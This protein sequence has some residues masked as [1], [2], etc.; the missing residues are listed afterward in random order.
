MANFDFE[1]RWATMLEDNGFDILCDA[2]TTTQQRLSDTAFK[3]SFMPLFMFAYQQSEAHFRVREP[4]RGAQ[5]SYVEES[6]AS[7]VTGFVHNQ[8]RL[9]TFLQ[10]FFSRKAALG[11][12]GFGAFG[13]LLVKH[14][15]EPHPF[16]NEADLSAW[17]KGN[18]ASTYANK[19]NELVHPKRRTLARQP[20]V[21]DCFLLLDLVLFWNDNKLF[22]F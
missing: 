16:G 11:K 6:Y 22:V 9:N 17:I 8:E 13:S 2:V 3:S 21:F 20:T 15:P 4:M 18:M 19:R 1:S 7:L 10:R 12:L 5:T 14:T